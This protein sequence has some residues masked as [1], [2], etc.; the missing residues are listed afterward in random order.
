MD[1]FQDQMEIKLTS[2]SLAWAWAELSLAVRY[3]QKDK[4]ELKDEDYSRLLRFFFDDV[5]NYSV[6]AYSRIMSLLVIYVLKSVSRR[7]KLFIYPYIF[8]LFLHG[9][10]ADK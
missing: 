4:G 5:T 1:G 8:I 2:A 7:F 10:L 6:I 9:K 3:N